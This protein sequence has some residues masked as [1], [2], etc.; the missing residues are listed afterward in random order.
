MKV[1]LALV[2]GVAAIAV[3]GA[4]ASPPRESATTPAKRCKKGY[5]HRIVRGKHVCVRIK[6]NKP[7]PVAR[8]T[9]RFALPGGSLDLET[10]DGSLWARVDANGIG[11]AD[12]VDRIDPLTGA[13][14]ARI[15]VREGVGLGI[16]GGAVWA[17]NEDQTLS[18]IDVR[19]NTVVATIPLP[20]S[21]P[22][23]AAT[24]AGAVWVTAMGAE[25]QPGSVTKLDPVTNA[26][27]AETKLEGSAGAFG[28]ASAGDAL[29]ANS[30]AGVIRI[31]ASSAA[32]SGSAGPQSCGGAVA[33]EAN[34]VWTATTCGASHLAIRVRYGPERRRRP[35]RSRPAVRAGRRRRA[36]IGL[37]DGG[38]S[39]PADS[40]RRSDGGRAWTARASDLG[41]GR[42]S[43]RRRLGRSA[44]A[45][46]ADRADA[47]APRERRFGRRYHSPAWRGGREV[48]QR[49]AK[50]RTPVR[51]RSAPPHRFVWSSGGSGG[52]TKTDARAKP[53]RPLWSAPPT[54]RVSSRSDGAR[55]ACGRPRAFHGG[56][57]P[58]SPVGPLPTAVHARFPR[59][60]APGGRSPPPL[61]RRMRAGRREAPLP[62]DPRRGHV[63]EP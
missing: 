55:P 18:K 44:R 43:V 53:A 20:N 46:P 49:P 42:G 2:V 54:G 61:A 29:W 4:G 8:I 12:E 35:P 23:D 22:Y 11:N 31:D 48:R 6:K 28:I 19:T 13:T 27:V 14:L 5:K 32:V 33:V 26:V 9:G 24:T 50:P 63:G 21:G 3:A 62:G 45:A 10:G 1:F 15:P 58:V 37:G 16:G 41:T 59:G 40:R 34:R 7:T 17:P 57:R 56:K 39:Q 25:G 38:E 51:I 36:R 52:E 47:V 30:E 60:N